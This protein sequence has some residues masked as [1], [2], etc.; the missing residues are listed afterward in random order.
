MTETWL[1]QISGPLYENVIWSRP[2]NK[3]LAGKL[4]IVG[5][6]SHELHEPLQAHKY[7]I[8][9]GIGQINIVM[10]D[11]IPKM[12]MSAEGLITVPSTMSGA[13]GYESLDELLAIANGVDMVLWPGSL[14]RDSQTTR[15]IEEFVEK[16]PKPVVASEDAADALLGL[17]GMFIRP[18]SLLILSMAQLAVLQ[19]HMKLTTAI[20]SDIQLSNLVEVLSSITRPGFGI[21]TLHSGQIVTSYNGQTSTTPIK[22]EDKETFRWRTALASYSAVLWA[23]FLYKPFEAIT[24]AAWLTKESLE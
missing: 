15:L 4:L 3:Q 5:G 13:I 21:A 24:S 11:R 10:P 2:E 18:D 1:K 9:A 17:P 14:G 7:C 22:M 6:N 23:Q 19:K 12:L 8:E 20:T 16:T